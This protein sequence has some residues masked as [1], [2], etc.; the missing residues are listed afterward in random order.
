MNLQSNVN[1]LVYQIADIKAKKHM[2]LKANTATAKQAD[3]NEV[4]VQPKQMNFSQEQVDYIMQHTQAAADRVR[5]E[6]QAAERQKQKFKTRIRNLQQKLN[7]T[8]VN[9]G[10][11]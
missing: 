11:Q 1:S 6:I 3:A 4:A 5:K 7:D 10:D 8:N 2:S 9:N